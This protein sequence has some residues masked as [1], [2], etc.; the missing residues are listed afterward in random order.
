[1]KNKTNKKQKNNPWSGLNLW[2][3]KMIIIDDYYNDDYR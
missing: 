3:Y 2:P 1:M